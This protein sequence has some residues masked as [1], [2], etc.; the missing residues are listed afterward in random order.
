MESTAC[1]YITVTESWENGKPVLLFYLGR[2]PVPRVAV[3]AANIA[4]LKKRKKA[5]PRRKSTR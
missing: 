2:E 4:H 5:K 3:T 1:S